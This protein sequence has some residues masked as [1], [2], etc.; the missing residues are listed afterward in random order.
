MERRMT[1]RN[2]LIEVI[3]SPAVLGAEIR[4]GDLRAIDAAATAVIRHAWLDHLV[5]LIRGQSLTDADLIAFG[6]G[7]GEFQYSNPLPSPL[8]NEGKVKQGGRA[9]R[10]PEITVVSNVVEN[11]VAVGGLG[12]GELVWHTD[13]SSFEEPPNQT[14]LY[15]LEV[16][17]VGGRTGFNNMY[18]AF[19][20]LPAKLRQRAEGL[21][22]KHDATTDAAGYTRKTYAEYSQ[23]DVK[24]LPGAVHPLVRTH[25][26][27]GRNC[28]FL[29]RRS[30]S[31]LVGL[32]VAESEH[33]LDQLWEHAT[34]PQLAWHHEW[35]PG[36]LLMWDNRCVMH[37]REP[38]DA[39]AR[40]M[41][42][43][44]VIKGSRPIRDPR[45][46]PPHARGHLHAQR[47]HAG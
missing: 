31:W 3:P 37:R 38:F 23:A 13:M 8:A 18:L 42:H 2:G 44:V 21:M 46:L 30:K 4:C 41:L 14:L 28:L 25:P 11:G 40:R 45:T 15:A 24:A 27:T 32:E 5:V 39:H 10:H 17:P 34:Q 19:D 36:D 47:V 33:L 1:T 9:D 43:R 35:L 12:D 29:G 26:E 7:F 16:P 22:L 20:T 6:R